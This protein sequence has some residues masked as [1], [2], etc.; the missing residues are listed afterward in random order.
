[1]T[2]MRSLLFAS[3]VAL[4]VA[5][6]APAFAASDVPAVASYQQ[7]TDSYSFP[8]GDLRITALSDGTVPQDLYKLL[9]GTSH[10]HTDQMLDK[11]FLE[12]P[13]EASINAFLVQSSNHTIL[14]DTGSG[15]LFGPGNGGKLLD[16]LASI[17][18]KA[19][20]VTDILITHIHTDHTGGL[21]RNGQP[22][23]PNATV[24]VGAPDLKFFLDPSNARKTGYAEQYFD[25]AAK[26]I[27]VYEK[28]GK[29]KTFG[30]GETILPG[31]TTSLHPGHTPG[32]A[33]FTVTSKDQ[34]MTFIGDVIHVAAVQFPDPD[35]TI[36]YD[37]K[38]E[39][40]ASVRKETFSDLAKRRELV[41]APHLP[42]PGVGY[43]R[44]EG[45][46]SFSWHPLEYRNRAGQ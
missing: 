8:L 27:G 20:E 10:S 3:A 4:S 24:F 11:E 42:F 35:V 43:I 7:V 16:S 9:I 26:T 39:D 22:A 25:E 36:V 23:F 19:D 37:V 2:T 45:A 5:V 29:V 17:G 18:V 34:S 13:V 32:S 21:V 15:D 33:F 12:S 38:P 1:M 41:A 28:L 44:A 46:G 31:I 6:S 30:E 14:V 40:A